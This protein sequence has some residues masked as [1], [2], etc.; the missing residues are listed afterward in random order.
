[1]K[2][3][4]F[5][6]SFDPITKGHEDII[7]RAAKLFDV[8]YVGIGVNQSKKYLFD[9]AAKLSMLN[10]VFKEVENVKVEVYEGL[11]LDFCKEKEAQFIIRG[12]RNSVD[13]EYEKNIA[14]MHLTLNPLVETVIMLTAPEYAAINSTIVRELIKNKA[15]VSAFVPEGLNLYEYL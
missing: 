11:T 12:L 5:P 9:T 2:V 6:G 10:Q 1:M 3:A 7:K 13:F 15:D 8:V 4:V 14:G